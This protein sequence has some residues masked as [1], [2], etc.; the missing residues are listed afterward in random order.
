MNGK[1]IETP[2]EMPKS[3]FGRNGQNPQEPNQ[4]CQPVTATKEEIQDSTSLME[5][6]LERQNMILAYKRVVKNKGSAG[7]DKM[8]VSELKDYLKKHWRQIKDELLAGTWG[9][10]NS[11][12]SRYIHQ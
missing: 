5:A 1:D 11:L 4:E 6:A 10:T 8:L 9:V 3:R 2:A 12:K 7:T